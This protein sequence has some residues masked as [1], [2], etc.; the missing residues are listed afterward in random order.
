MLRVNVCTWVG[1]CS[2]WDLK[3]EV[4]GYGVAGPSLLNDNVSEEVVV[5]DWNGSVI[6]HDQSWSFIGN[7]FHTMNLIP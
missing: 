2:T 6:V 1:V 4:V 7:L 5:V 3:E